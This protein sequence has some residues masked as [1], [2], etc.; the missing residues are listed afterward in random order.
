MLEQEVTL[1]K[2]N[3][4]TNIRRKNLDLENFQR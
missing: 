4:K 3:K 1:I 2:I